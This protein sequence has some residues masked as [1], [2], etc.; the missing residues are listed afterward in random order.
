MAVQ[1]PAMVKVV[2][3]SLIIISFVVGATLFV[4]RRNIHPLPQR[5]RVLIGALTLFSIT[6]QLICHLG[7]NYFFDIRVVFLLLFVHRL[8]LLIFFIY[9]FFWLFLLSS[10]GWQAFYV[11]CNVVRWFSVITLFGNPP[12]WIFPFFSKQSYFRFSFFSSY[13]HR[14]RLRVMVDCVSHVRTLDFPHKSRE[15]DEGRTGQ[16]KSDF[17]LQIFRFFF[18][19]TLTHE[20]KETWI[21]WKRWSSDSLLLTV[22]ICIVVFFFGLQLVFMGIIEGT[23]EL[24]NFDQQ[25]LTVS[26]SLFFFFTHNLSCICL[27]ALTLCQNKDE[28]SN[29]DCNK[30]T[31]L[32]ATLALGVVV[33][34]IIAIPLG[35]LFRRNLKGARDGLKLKRELSLLC[36]LA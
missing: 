7:F 14:T 29:F 20:Q 36:L 11:P 4:L 19:S 24:D 6:Y 26:F 30:A 3:S 1:V 35:V 27:I 15:V 34:L 31:S 12:R 10:S 13:Q 8:F 21:R 22:L 32:T 5:S 33:F 9:L 2:S 28:E 18:F 25:S 16:P 17:S 23:E